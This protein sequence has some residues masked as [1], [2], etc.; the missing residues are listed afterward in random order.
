[1]IISLRKMRLITSTAWF[2][3]SISQLFETGL[4]QTRGS[5]SPLFVIPMRIISKYKSLRDRR[6]HKTEVWCAGINR[7]KAENENFSRGRSSEPL[8]PEFCVACPRGASRSVNRGIGG[9]GMELRKCS[10]RTPTSDWRKA[11]CCRDASASPG[12]V[13][14]SRRPQRRLDTF[15]TRT[16]RPPRCP[17]LVGTDG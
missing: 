14:R 7:Q 4:A 8:G 12:T 6:L 16:G 3:P 5:V 17:E 9:L 1:M 13:L 15:C 10:T 2:M 11:T